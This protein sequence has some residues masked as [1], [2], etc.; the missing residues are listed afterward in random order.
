M[1]LGWAGAGTGGVEAG[2]VRVQG[3]EGLDYKSAGARDVQTEGRRIE[4]SWR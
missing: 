1:A 4:C 2:G 3:V